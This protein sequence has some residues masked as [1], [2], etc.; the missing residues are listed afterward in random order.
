MP[1]PLDSCFTLICECVCVSLSTICRNWF[2]LSTVRVC[3]IKIRLLGLGTGA[4]THS[5]IL[6]A[7]DPTSC[8][9][10]T[11]L[12]EKFPD[13]YL[14]EREDPGAKLVERARKVKNTKQRREAV[15]VHLQASADSQTCK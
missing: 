10:D 4:F 12:N 8:Y 6:C 14:Q 1:M 2:S 15:T 7:T 5:R 13:N 3:E 9:S 11:S